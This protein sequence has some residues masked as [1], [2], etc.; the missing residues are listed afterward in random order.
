[1]TDYIFVEKWAMDV[2]IESIKQFDKENYP[3]I[4]IV[5]DKILYDQYAKQQVYE[6]T[7]PIVNLING[8]SI[9]KEGPSIPFERGPR[10]GSH[11]SILSHPMSSYCLCDKMNREENYGVGKDLCKYLTTHEHEIN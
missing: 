5:N 7:Y 11:V 4:Y 10:D 1:M 9:W 8:D 3:N 2:K 6:F